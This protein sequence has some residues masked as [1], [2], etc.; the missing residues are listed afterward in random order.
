[1]FD[2]KDV[3]DVKVLTSLG[4][5]SVISCENNPVNSTC[6]SD[7]CFY[8]ILMAGDVNDAN[9]Q[10][11]DG[12]RCKSE[13]DRHSSLLFGL[14]LVRVTSGQA[15]Y[16]CCFAVVYMTGSTES[17]VLLRCTHRH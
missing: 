7:H 8:K 17:D 15:F 14:E 6:A 10:A 5:D 11:G 12:T 16:Q 9:F 2:A 3:E 4:H 13:V 1:M